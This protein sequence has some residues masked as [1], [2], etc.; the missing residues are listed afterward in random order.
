MY[1]IYIYIYNFKNFEHCES[2]RYINDVILKIPLCCKFF[3]DCC[4]WL[5]DCLSTGMKLEVPSKVVFI[6]FLPQYYNA[7]ML[8]TF[9]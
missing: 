7:L 1:F 4:I 2:E 8:S 3:D 6:V 9:S 5:N